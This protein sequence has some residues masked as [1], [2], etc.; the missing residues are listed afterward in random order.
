VRTLSLAHAAAG[1]LLPGATVVVNN[2]QAGV[3]DGTLTQSTQNKVCC[4]VYSSRVHQAS[5]FGFSVCCCLY[6]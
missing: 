1:I 5:A 6:L 3:F 4:P 2:G